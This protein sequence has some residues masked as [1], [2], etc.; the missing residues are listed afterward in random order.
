[1][2]NRRHLWPWNLYGMD[3]KFHATFK[4]GTE[5][6]SIFHATFDHL[7]VLMWWYWS[8]KYKLNTALY[9]SVALV[10]EWV[11]IIGRSLFKMPIL[12]TKVYQIS[13]SQGWKWKPIIC[14]Q[15]LY[16]FSNSP[17]IW[18]A[19]RTFFY[20]NLIAASVECSSRIVEV[21]RWNEISRAKNFFA[22]FC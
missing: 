6:V 12:T 15:C 5:K 21:A 3:G 19:S 22:T 20:E 2:E 17:A 4:S 13:A 7:I 11:K 10:T 14:M 16:A 18:G 1:M 8:P 9:I